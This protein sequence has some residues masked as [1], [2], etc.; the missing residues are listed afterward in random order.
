MLH[1]CRKGRRPLA[2]GLLHEHGLQNQSLLTPALGGF[3]P[4]HE[5]KWKESQLTYDEPRAH[6]CNRPSSQG[7][8]QAVL[9]L[10]LRCRWL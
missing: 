6:A 3:K 5:L 1:R 2:K 10:H 9:L 7:A 8:P 4:S